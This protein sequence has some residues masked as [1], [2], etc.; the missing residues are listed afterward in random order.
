MVGITEK[1]LA[2]IDFAKAIGMMLIYVCRDI[3]IRLCMLSIY[4]CFSSLAAWCSAKTDIRVLR[5]S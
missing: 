5:F 3:V 1:R 2:Y 4:L